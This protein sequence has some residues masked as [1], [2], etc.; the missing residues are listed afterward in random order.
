M[1]FSFL[2]G[3]SRCS[4]PRQPSRRRAVR[5]LRAARGFDSKA[6]M[7]LARFCV[8]LALLSFAASAVAEPKAYDLIRYRGKAEGLTIAFDFGCGYPEASEVRIKRRR[9]GKSDRFR[10][11]DEGE[12]RFVPETNRVRG[13]EVTLQMRADDEPPRNCAVRIARAERQSGSRSRSDSSDR[14]AAFCSRSWSSVALSRAR[15]GEDIECGE[16]RMNS[17]GGADHA[18][19]A[20][21]DA[22]RAALQFRGAAGSR[23][24]CRSSG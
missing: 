2:Q 14:T 16:R 12:M 4:G 24:E 21:G 11:V 1:E 5:R 17:A 13:E 20:A 10:L 22:S 7:R 3:A 19:A 23:R 8:V 9:R 18:V 15:L 6:M